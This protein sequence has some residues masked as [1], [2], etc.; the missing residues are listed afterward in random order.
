MRV[1]SKKEVTSQ[2]KEASVLLDVLGDDV[3]RARAY[4]TALRQLDR[5][6]GDFPTLF[7]ERRLTEVR[8]IGD[9]LAAEIYALA[10]QDYLP[11]LETLYTSVPVGVRDLLKVSGLGAKKVQQLWHAGI[12]SLP[13]LLAAAESGELAKLKGF[14]GKGVARIKVAAQFAYDAAQFLRLDQAEILAAAFA[15]ALQETA[16]EAELYWVGEFR[17]RLEVI[18]AFELVVVGKGGTAVAQALSALG[19]TES[20]APDAW[21]CTFEGYAMTVYSYPE[22]AVAAAL[23]TRTGSAQFVADAAGGRDLTGVQGKD[24]GAVFAALGAP[25]IPP[26][27]RDLPFAQAKLI[28]PSLLELPDIRGLVHN[29]T[30]ASDGAASLAEMV[31]AARARGFSYLAIADHSKSSFYANGLD[32]V[33]LAEQQV[34]VALHREALRREGDFELLHGCEVDIKQDGTLDFED[35]VLAA[36]DYTVV[37]VHQHFSLSKS[38]Q[39]ER[40]VAA[41][42]H[43]Y[44]DILAHMTGRLLLRRPAY[45]VDVL[46]VLRACAQTGTIVEINANPRR[47]DLDWRLVLKAAELGCQFAINP[48]AH[49]PQG[50]DVLRYGVL[51][52]RKAGLSAAD[53]INT[54]GDARSFLRRLKERGNRPYLHNPEQA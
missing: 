2:L 48:D 6:S 43:P 13:T 14:G 21:L 40:I 31:A 19:P 30:H 39:T 3:N 46:E 53:V 9:S 37:S 34:E 49:S 5:F 22:E 17:R 36:L 41:V 27:C 42:H 8:G 38:A 45:D 29:H 16:P 52:A 35:E 54:A 7:A 25:W 20:L 12:D 23:F 1:P 26:E 15:A 51:M 11:A 33:R 32:E 18:R 44:A 24:E 10:S 4:A 47:L 50:Y 28:A